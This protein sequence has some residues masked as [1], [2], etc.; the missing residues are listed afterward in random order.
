MI[1][2]LTNKMRSCLIMF[3]VTAATQIKKILGNCHLQRYYFTVK[4]SSG[5]CNI[6]TSWL[7]FNYHL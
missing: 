4:N 2:Y 3:R 5:G 1:L 6:I 7:V